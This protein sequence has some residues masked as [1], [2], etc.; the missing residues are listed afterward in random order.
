VT[1]FVGSPNVES[2]HKK[3]SSRTK[4]FITWVHSM[5]QIRG[6][7]SFLNFALFCH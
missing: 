4:Y 2:G 7:V 6:N 3:I 1:L 5:A